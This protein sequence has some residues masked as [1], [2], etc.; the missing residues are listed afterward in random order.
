MSSPS[1]REAPIRGR[2]TSIERSPRIEEAERRIATVS[3][4]LDELVTV[5]GTTHRFGLDSVVGLIPGFG[6]IASAAIG[7][8]IIAEAAR[9]RLPAV[10]LVRMVVNTLVD[11]VVGVVPILGDAFDFFFKSNTRN[12]AL[13]RRHATDPGAST[14]E[15]K[16]FLAGL[17][18]L[19]VGMVWLVALAVGRL[20]SIEVPAP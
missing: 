13:F 18:L 1:S 2:V 20:L 6:D 5:P 15:H 9:F 3:R 7:V 8:W 19:L 14:T 12:L 4:L 17:V 16:A 10:V 11:F